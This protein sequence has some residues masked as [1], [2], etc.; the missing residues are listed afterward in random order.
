MPP[1]CFLETD[2]KKIN[3][4]MDKI[5]KSKYYAFLMEIKKKIYQD[6]RM[7]QVFAGYK[8][9]S[10]TEKYRQSGLVTIL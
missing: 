10:S 9:I 2:E 5:Q 6:L 8:K 1:V 4:N 3:E 7:V